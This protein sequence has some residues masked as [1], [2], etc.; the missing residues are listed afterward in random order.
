MPTDYQERMH[1]DIKRGHTIPLFTA[2]GLRVAHSYTRCVYGER[3]PYIEFSTT[4][5]VISALHIPENLLW[6]TTSN[7]DYVEYR[8][9]DAAAVKVYH[10]QRRVPYA[11][12]QPGMLYISPFDLHTRAGE[13]LI[14]PLRAAKTQQLRLF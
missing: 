2:T 7:V 6:K 3:G 12:Y 5:M 10:Q 1:P 14:L 4:E 9:T 13:A 11:D 8:T